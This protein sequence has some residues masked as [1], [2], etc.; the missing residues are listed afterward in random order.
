MLTFF[1]KLNMIKLCV[2]FKKL[3]KQQNKPEKKTLYILVD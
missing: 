3:E 2:Q 1:K